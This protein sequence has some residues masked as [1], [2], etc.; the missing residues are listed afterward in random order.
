[1]RSKTIDYTGWGE[2]HKDAK[3]TDADKWR[4]EVF[5]IDPKMLVLHEMA[6]EHPK[7]SPKR[8][9]SFK[10]EMAIDGQKYPVITFRGK[11]VDGRHRWWAL[12]ENNA[13]NILYIK[14]PHRSTDEAIRK[15][16]GLS[17]DRRH[18]T[19]TQRAIKAYREGKKRGEKFRETAARVGISHSQF[20]RCKFIEENIGSNLLNHLWDGKTVSVGARDNLD[21][22][23]AIVAEKRRFDK[24]EEQKQNAS[25]AKNDKFSPDSPDLFRALGYIETLS[26]KD[27]GYVIDRM[28]QERKVRANKDI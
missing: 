11:I 1:M 19:P 7:M 12:N 16:V 17:E 28:S 25:A 3:A 9:E 22:L 20:S 15:E 2:G 13:E 6:N 4:S 18:Q 26:E 5:E 10:N 14:M 23:S 27:F 24:E 21:S 8:F